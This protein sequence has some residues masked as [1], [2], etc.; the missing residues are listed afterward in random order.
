MA[1]FQYDR[2]EL[3]SLDRTQPIIRL[4]RFIRGNGV[5][6][7]CEIFQAW[8][9]QPEDIIPYEALSYT[10][11]R[12]QKTD[13]ILVNGNKLGITKNLYLALRYLRLEDED[14]ILW[15]DG[16]CINQGNDQEKGHQVQQMGNIYRQAERVLIWLGPATSGTNVFME[17]MMKLEKE[18]LN[19][20][21][22]S[23]SVSGQ[24]L[25]QRCLD[26]WSSIK[27]ELRSI[28]SNLELRQRHGLEAIFERPW[29]RRVWILQ[30]VAN[31]RAAIV[32]C[33]VKSVSAQIFALGPSLTGLTPDAHCQ[34]I[35]DIMPGKPREKFWWSK[36]RDLHTLLSKFR[37]SSASDPRDN[38]YALLGLSSDAYDSDL[39]QPDY[40]KSMRDVMNDTASFLLQVPE[41]GKT[42]FISYWTVA[43]IPLF[44]EDMQSLYGAALN[45]AHT[46]GNESIPMRLLARG[47]VD[48]NSRDKNGETPLLR[49]AR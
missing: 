9:S 40:S 47:D 43:T 32:I 23:W 31:A 22:N 42:D 10:W 12:N 44:L 14:R 30:E 35:L 39:L 6:I 24:V 3:D 37:K 19:S 41:L 48:A 49:A 8:L 28:H 4:V 17:S 20:P 21:K 26:T 34:S 2:F 27:P 18:S 33:G 16:I 11:G 1:L 25:S 5:E 36:K 45:W 15:V 7:H 38:I 46:T 13:D 29:F